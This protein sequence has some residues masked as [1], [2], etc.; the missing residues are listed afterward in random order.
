MLLPSLVLLALTAAAPQQ[1]DA[2]AMEREARRIEAMLI[3]PCC[4]TQ[5]VSQHQSQASDEVK[6]QV[7][8]LLTAGK[9]RQEVLD[10]FVAQYGQRILAEPPVRGAGGVLY[11]GLAVAFLLTGAALVAWVRRA[12]RRPPAPAAAASP[13]AAAADAAYAARLDDELRDMD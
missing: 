5:P 4:W 12:S 7:R 9:S 8:T 3:A 6:R 10:A 11:G 13:G 1:P 2:A